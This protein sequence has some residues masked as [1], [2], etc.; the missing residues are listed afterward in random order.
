MTGPAETSTRSIGALRFWAGLDGLAVSVGAAGVLPGKTIHLFA[1][2]GCGEGSPC[3]QAA[4]SA[5]GSVPGIAW[6]TAFVGFAYFIAL[7]AAWI[8]SARAGAVPKAIRA[9]VRVGA[10]GSVL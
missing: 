1:A 4:A 7:A 5:F 10:A 2:P 3:E 9:L 6:P 8:A